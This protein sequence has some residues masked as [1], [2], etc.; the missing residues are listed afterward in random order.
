VVAPSIARENA[1]RLDAQVTITPQQNI[2]TLDHGDTETET[3]V[4]VIK[5][6]TPITNVKLVPGGATAP[7]VTSISPAGGYGPLAPNQE[8]KLTFEVTFTGVVPCKEKEQVLTGTIDVV[9]ATERGER[10]LERK[11]LQITVPACDQR[12]QLFSYSVKF[13]CGVQEECACSC[14]PVRPGSYATEINIY[15]FH[16]VEVPIRKIV[17]PVVL[18]GAAIGREPRWGESRRPDKIVLP[19]RTATM[20]DC[21]RIAVLLI[22]GQP[23][24]TLPLTVGFME[25]VSTQELAVSAVY[26]ATDLKGGSISIDVEQIMARRAGVITRPSIT[27]AS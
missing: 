9:V 2:L 25:I 13:V 14:A 17:V 6:G 24:A 15:N 21:C 3:I 22:G 27:V 11:R 8:H 16:P 4:V 7:F 26:T 19:P 10:V 12:R 23:S 18:A 20:D 5:S 1:S